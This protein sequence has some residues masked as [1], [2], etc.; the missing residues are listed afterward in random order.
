MS[1]ASQKRPFDVDWR[2]HYEYVRQIRIKLERV[3][4]RQPNEFRR[5]DVRLQIILE[6]MDTL[7]LQRDGQ[8]NQTK[9]QGRFVVLDESFLF[10]RAFLCLHGSGCSPLSADTGVFGIFLANMAIGSIS[11]SD[12]SRLSSPAD[13]AR[14][15]VYLERVPESP[16]SISLDNSLYDEAIDDDG[17]AAYQNRKD[18]RQ[19]ERYNHNELAFQMDLLQYE[20]DQQTKDIRRHRKKINR[21]I[22]RKQAADKKSQDEAKQER[23]DPVAQDGVYLERL[24]ESFSS[25]PLD[26]SSYDEAIEDD[27]IAAYQSKSIRRLQQ[28]FK[29]KI[30]RL[31]ARDKKSHDKVDQERTGPASNDEGDEERK[32][33]DRPLCNKLWGDHYIR[34]R[35]HDDDHCSICQLL[36]RTL[37]RPASPEI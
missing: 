25:I 16:S 20:D 5:R 18:L 13:I 10:G 33:A 26:N 15:K 1:A 34:N 17:I 6:S 30:A 31:Q 3:V 27:G 28:K 7:S 32:R 2:A 24:P 12:V 14:I 35:A 9:L 21:E 19:M 29:R 22:A 8:L 36:Q 37:Q 11:R 4:S 23:T